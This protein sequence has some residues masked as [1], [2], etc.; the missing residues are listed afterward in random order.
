MKNHILTQENN[1]ASNAFNNALEE[2][3]REGAS[4]LLQQA[5]ENEVNEYLEKHMHLKGDDNT[6]AIIR[7]GYLPKR[8][9]Q[10]GIGPIKHIPLPASFQYLSF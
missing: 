9:V 7:N 5:I 2:T 8:E 6:R 4:K 1:H 10:T 3:L